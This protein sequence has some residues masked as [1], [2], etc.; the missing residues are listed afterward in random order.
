MSEIKN[1]TIASASIT[2]D[3]HG[4]LG[5]WIGMDYG[6]G[7]RQSFGGYAL[8]LPKSFTNHELKSVAGHWMYRCLKVAG[9]NDWS[10]MTGR[11][12]RVQIGDD[13][14]I[15]GIGHITENDWFFPKKEFTK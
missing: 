2:N 5:S 9:T 6:H 10:K 8:Y 4:C 3:D 7:L 13:G 1:A 14:S 11:T 15:E 12:V